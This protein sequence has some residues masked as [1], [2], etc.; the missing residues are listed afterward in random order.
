MVSRS[1]VDLAEVKRE[2]AQTYGQTLEQ[3]IKDDISGDYKRLM[4]AI[5]GGN[6]TICS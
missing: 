4:I 1:E 6:W 5:A 2:F 3:F